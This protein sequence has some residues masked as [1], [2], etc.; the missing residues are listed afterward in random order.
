[1]SIDTQR[2]E[3]DAI[4][5]LAKQYSRTSATPIVDDDYPEVRL[6]YERA[7][8][9][10]IQA[11]RENGR[12]LVRGDLRAISAINLKRANRWHKGGIAE[13]I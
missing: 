10:A 3:F 7:I 1:M 5:E 13:R 11:M 12:F 8:S 9:V 4:A 6:E 2:A